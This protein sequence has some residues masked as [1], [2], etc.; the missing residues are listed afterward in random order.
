M[1][2]YALASKVADIEKKVA[3]CASSDKTTALMDRLESMVASLTKRVSNDFVTK[4]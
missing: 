3:K 1:K 2:A 4:D